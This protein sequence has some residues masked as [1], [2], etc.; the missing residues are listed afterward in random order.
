MQQ[1]NPKFWKNRSVFVTGHTGFKGAWLSLWLHQMEAK[2]HGYSQNPPTTPSL[3]EVANLSELFL[4]DT[5]ADLSDL[6]TLK[7]SL[8]NS[9]AEVLLHLAA[10]PNVRESYRDPL[11]TMNSNVMGTAQILQLAREV[12]SLKSIVIITTDKVYEN[13]EWPFPYREVD[14]LGGYGP[15]SA[16]KA[17][18]EIVVSSFRSSFFSGPSGHPAKIASVRAG[19]VIGGGDW[20]PDRLVPDA[21]RAYEKKEAL[22]LRYPAAVRPWQHVLEPLSGYL[23]V[24]EKLLEAD[25]QTYARAWNFGPDITGD[26]TVSEVAKTISELF[27]Q[28]TKVE[29]KPSEK[30]P[31]EAGLL[32]LDST[33]ARTILG[34]TPLWDLKTSLTKTVEWHQAYLA[35]KD[36]RAFTVSQ[37][38]NYLYQ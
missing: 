7:M 27:D 26:A 9:K 17:A 23:L 10:Q 6:E 12:P 18:A 32:R 15:Y 36:M 20:A 1:V 34:W 38:E 21:L 29:A 11:G 5:R 25:G 30:N 28:K 24:A 16:S 35:K 14:P 13:R 37:I 19:N 3:F 8:V 2:I 4:T 33:L 31:H 22:Q